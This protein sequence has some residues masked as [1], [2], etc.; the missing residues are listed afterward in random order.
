[1]RNEARIYNEE[2]TVSS[3]NGVEKTGELYAK[4]S[5]CTT[6]SNSKWIKVLKSKTQTENFWNKI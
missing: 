6:I 5:N 3:I 4:E 1:M 2:K